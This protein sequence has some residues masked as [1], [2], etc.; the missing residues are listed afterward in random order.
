[1]SNRHH[2]GKRSHGWMGIHRGHR[3][4][5]LEWLAEKF[6]FAVALSA[7]LVV[8]LIFLFVAREAAPLLFGHI[9]SAA[10]QPVIPVSEMD[11]LPPAQLQEYLGLTSKEFAGMARETL[12]SL[13]EVKVEA[14]DEIPA[15]FRND[16]DAQI[17]A[18][19]G[20]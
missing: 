1:M 19:A 14:Q 3:A 5:P 18:I 11:K 13:M 16:P 17:N 10:V 20:C 12:T 6:I 9:N 4:R 2:A 15:A 7:I 8:L